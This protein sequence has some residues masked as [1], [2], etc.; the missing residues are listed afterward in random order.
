M[1]Q[2]HAA[3]A[4]MHW[5]THQ[6]SS[7]AFARG[8]HETG[9]GSGCCRMPGCGSAVVSLDCMFVPVAICLVILL[10]AI[11]TPCCPAKRVCVHIADDAT[12]SIL[13]TTPC[14]HAQSHMPFAT[15]R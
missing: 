10:L 3:T 1:L 12:R 14:N 13:V 15:L 8:A 5:K 9:K 7:T 4:D 2:L 11:L 6:Y